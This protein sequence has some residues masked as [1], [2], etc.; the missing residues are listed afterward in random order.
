MFRR[1]EEQ[2]TDVELLQWL[3]SFTSKEFEEYVAYLFERNG[4]KATVVGKSHDKGVD[5]IANREGFTYYIQCKRFTDF[6]VKVEQVRD[7]YGAIAD[8]LNG[9]KGYFVTT[10]TYTKEAKEFAK[11]KRLQLFDREDLIAMIRRTKG[12]EIIR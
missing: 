8:R 7:F 6:K 11:G 1:G 12:K 10:S 9:G 4:F 3:R 2:K 5:V